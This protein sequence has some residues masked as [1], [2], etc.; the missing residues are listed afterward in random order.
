MKIKKI[1]DL[2]KKVK[3]FDIIIF[4][5]DDTIYCQAYYDTPALKLVS[6]YLSNIINIKPLKIFSDIRKI[7]KLRR[8]KHP[9]LVFNKY[10]EKKILSKK[11]LNKIID[12]SV[13]IFQTYNCKNLKYITSLK[14][15]IKRLY[16]DRDLFLVTNGNVQRQKR[17]INY[18]GIK[19]Y[20][21]R[22]FILD[23]IKKKIKP[24]ITHVKYLDNYLRKKKNYRAVYIGDN[25][26]S[27]RKFAKN[28]D[29]SFIHFEFN[30]FN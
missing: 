15:L 18:L 22:I 9:L 24:S 4:D 20:F 5:L 27:D 16:K 28:L 10:L 8:G 1:N 13:R 11:D 25:Y 30:N 23:G 21:N 19:N 3:N 17:K 2:K 7:K 29:I 12:N 26:N 14:P 6:N